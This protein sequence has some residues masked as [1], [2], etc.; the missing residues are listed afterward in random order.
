MEI[1]IREASL[2]SAASFAIYKEEI[3]KHISCKL[4]ALRAN[5]I[6]LWIFYLE[7][8]IR[9]K[10]WLSPLRDSHPFYFFRLDMIT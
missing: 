1:L 8:G 2:S 7:F 9:R 3:A 4:F 5:K 6:S 10:R